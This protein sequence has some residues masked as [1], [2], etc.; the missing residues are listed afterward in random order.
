MHG[1]GTFF[2]PRLNNAAQFPI[3]TANGFGDLLHINPDDNLITSKLPSLQLYQLYIP[4]PNPTVAFDKAA[5]ARGD[6][7]FSEK[8]GCNNCHAEPLWTEPPGSNLH[9]PS[10][11]GPSAHECRDQNFLCLW[12]AG[13]SQARSE[14]PSV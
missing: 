13:I 10:S 6:Q 9:P 12:N 1:K 8:A 14:K 3:A 11:A 5:A 7:L 4:A 2:D